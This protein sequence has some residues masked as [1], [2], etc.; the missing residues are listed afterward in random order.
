MIGI[1]ELNELL[2][3]HTC[4]RGINIQLNDEGLTYDLSLSMSASESFESD[5][6]LIRFTDVSNFSARDIG[7]GLTQMMHLK[8]TELNSGWD[9]M[10]Y[11]LDELE[12]NNMF[13][14]F[15][16]FVVD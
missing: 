12:D 1:A 3:T 8:V 6:V 16:S 14:Y 11:Q 13:F 5:A 15:S 9:R 2:V 7:G 10:H 4:F